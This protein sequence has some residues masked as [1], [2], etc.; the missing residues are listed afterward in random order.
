MK[1]MT[2][3]ELLKEFLK[4]KAL[5]DALIKKTLEHDLYKFN[6]IILSA[7]KGKGKVPLAPFHKEMCTFIEKDKNKKKLILVPRGHLK[8]TL[9]TIGYSV[10]R[11]A[12]DPSI[13]ILIANATYKMAVAF[14]SEIKKHLQNN[15]RLIEIFGSMAQD[16]LKW[17]E[18]MIT[19]KDAKTAHGKKEATVTAFG[20]GGNLVSQHYDIIIL[21]DIV[22]RDMINTRDQIE[23]TI[24]FYKDV[25]D[26]ADSEK[27]EF[28]VIGTR[29]H[30][31][32][33]Y[34]WIM[35]KDNQ[36]IQGFN[37]MIKQAYEGT[38][39]G[40]DYQPLW[41]DKFTQPY[42]KG[43]LR[44]KGPYEFSTQYMNNPVPDE[45]A[46]FKIH[47]FKYYE[48]TELKGRPMNKYILVDPAISLE[49][50]ADYTAMVVVGIDHFGYW[51]ILDIFRDRVTPSQLI[52]QIFYLNE[53]WRPLDIGVEDVAF[54]KTLQYSLHEEMRKRDIYLPLREVKPQLRS[55]D[56]R[57]RGLQPL[58][59]NGMIYHNKDLVYNEYLEDE[60]M[61]YPRARHDD[62]VDAF[63][64][65][66][67]IVNTP[68]RQ[69][70]QHYDSVSYS[71]FV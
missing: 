32:D 10:Q 48:P 20:M 14:L 50:E 34:D 64:Y 61:R 9:I 35:N 28:I 6:K 39:E 71:P 15:E 66:K 36:I 44:D 26:L 60:L 8:S 29:W 51:Y 62:I 52:S 40:E 17:S 4:D 57:I 58:Y 31:R 22:N 16:P 38:L 43:L 19:L 33:L 23:K 70:D 30:D 2:K 5:D 27:T 67:D 13:R 65:A 7:E 45:D 24:L 46:V 25:L 53:Q 37:V 63:S 54:Q 56:E 68:K 49:K 42:I 47:W 3:E 69:R 41:K 11:I 12:Y 18:D 59:A 55:K 21:D 1:N